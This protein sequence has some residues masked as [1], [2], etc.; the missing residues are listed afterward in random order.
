M[1]PLRQ[2]ITPPD[3]EGGQLVR[4]HHKVVGRAY[5]LQTMIVFLHRA[6]LNPEDEDDVAVSDLIEWNGGGPHTWV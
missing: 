3:H 4:S 5:D 1:R 2:G 6:S